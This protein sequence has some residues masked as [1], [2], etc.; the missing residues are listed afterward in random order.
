[1]TA[2]VDVPRDTTQPTHRRHRRDEEQEAAVTRLVIRGVPIRE[3]GFTYGA[4]TRGSIARLVDRAV[5]SQLMELDADLRQRVDHA[6]L[7]SLLEAWWDRALDGQAEAA[8]I[9]LTAIALHNDLRHVAFGAANNGS[10]IAEG[11]ED[12]RQVAEP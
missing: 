12:Q 3:I 7:E 10:E 8:S 4:G 1:M 9:V 11:R 6:R 2:T 5:R